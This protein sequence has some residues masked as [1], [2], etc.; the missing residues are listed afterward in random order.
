MAKKRIYGLV[1]TGDQTDK[2][3]HEARCFEIFQKGEK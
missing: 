1:Q 3:F 2:L